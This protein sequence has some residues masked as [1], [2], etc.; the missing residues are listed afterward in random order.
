M[1]IA[2]VA[3]I[4]V[5]LYWITESVQLEKERFT[6]N[7]KETLLRIS[8]KLEKHETAN[9]IIRRFSENGSE[10]ICDTIYTNGNTL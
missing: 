8:I 5:Q 7:V 3:L 1:T 2:V 6:G 10:E 9:V 4:C